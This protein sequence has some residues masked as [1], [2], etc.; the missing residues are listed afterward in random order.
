MDG[1]F[2]SVELQGSAARGRLSDALRLFAAAHPIHQ[3]KHSLQT[4]VGWCA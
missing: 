2:L 3:H 4:S 1:L